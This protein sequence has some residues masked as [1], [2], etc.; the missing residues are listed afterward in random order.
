MCGI[1]GIAHKDCQQIENEILQQ[2]SATMI[3]RG[4]DGYG[5]YYDRNIGMAMR[6]L[7]IIDLAH[8]W[9]PF[10]SNAGNVVAFQNG[11][12]YN[13]RILQQELKH[14][15]YCFKT[16]SDTEVLAHGYAAWGIDGLLQRLDGMY[17]IAIYDK[18]RRELHLA[19]DRFGEKPLFYIHADDYFVY[20]SNTVALNILPWLDIKI[21]PESLAYYLALHYVPGDKTIFTHIHRV[22]PGERLCFHIDAFRKNI[23]PY[24]ELPLQNSLTRPS[25]HR[26]IQTIESSVK[27]RLIADVPVGVFLSGGIDSSVIAAIAAQYQPRIDTFSMGFH[28]SEVDESRYAQQ[29]A[30]QIHSNHHHFYFDEQTFMT[31]LPEVVSSLDEPVGDQALLPLY[32]LCR[33]AKK[34]VTVVLSGEGG[35]EIFGGYGY[36]EDFVDDRRFLEKIKTYFTRHSPSPPLLDSLINNPIPTTPSGFPLLTDQSTRELLIGIYHGVNGFETQLLKKLNLCQDR[37]QR[38]MAADIFTWLPDDLLV[39]FDRM[40]MRH[41]LE[42][43][44]PYLHPEI[45]AMG[46]NLPPKEKIF[47]GNK[48]RYFK[49]IAG[50]W[51]PQTII[52][53][54]KQGFILPMRQWIQQWFAQHGGAQRYFCKINF[55]HLNVRELDKLVQDDINA[56]ILR[57]R[58]LFAMIILF[59]WYAEYTTRIQRFKSAST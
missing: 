7:S 9:Q 8:G 41:S 32:W 16:D 13:Y 47:R 30:D 48:K 24:Y 10:M 23:L 19:R 44:A 59:E 34:Y 37:L 43:R 26:L 1:V 42:G 3:N 5:E 58:L 35:D 31:L 15:G 45:V 14:A 33:E 25:K 17:A 20:S 27:S 53:R 6:R 50:Q 12:I 21:D 40:A 55:P 11:E 57:E 52:H 4:P 38:A 18:I 56:G 28:A 51:L 22:L 2:M 36:Y 29:V 49:N 54:R 46:L 39:K